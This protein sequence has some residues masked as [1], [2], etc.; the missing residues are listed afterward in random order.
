MQTTRAGPDESLV[1][2][3][4]PT[5]ATN[6]IAHR[7]GAAPV[8]APPKSTPQGKLQGA[9]DDTRAR[10]PLTQANREKTHTGW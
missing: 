1:P 10:P 6:S 7:L 9:C 8:P 3:M 4:R 5:E 2:R